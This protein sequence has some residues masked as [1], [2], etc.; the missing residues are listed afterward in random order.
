MARSFI[1][2]S[3]MLLALAHCADPREPPAP[4]PAFERRAKPLE[5]DHGSISLGSSMETELSRGEPVHTWQFSLSAEAQVTLSTQASVEH[6]PGERDVDTVLVLQQVELSGAT[7]WLAQND[8]VGSSRYSRISRALPAGSYQVVVHGFRATT[9]G[10]FALAT[11]CSGQGCPAPASGCW[12]GD[13]FSDLRTHASLV[14]ASETWLT[15]SDQIANEVERAQVVLAVQQSTHTD[16]TTLEAALAVVDQS[17]VRRLELHDSDG[18]VYL[19]FEYG[20]GDNSY[21]AIF[22]AGSTRVL[23]SIHDGDLLSCAARE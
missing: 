3:I 21:G 23:A 6:P 12:F 2:C 8:D 11:G 1:P 5:S 17:E 15:A 14:V 4:T 9:R 13:T 16:V 20:V 22:A 19:A 10:R 18:R 7:R